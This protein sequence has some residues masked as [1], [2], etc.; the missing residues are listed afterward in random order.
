MTVILKPVRWFLSLHAL[1]RMREMGIERDEVVHALDQP[2][3]VYP[4]REGRLGAIGGRLCVI[5]DD[6]SVVT[7]LWR[8]LEGR[9]AA[10]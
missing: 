8:G 2:E 4:V 10:P 9:H 7:V 3:V 6:D 5:I 1:E